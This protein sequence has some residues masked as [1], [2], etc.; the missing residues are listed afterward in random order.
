[1]A[2]NG[3]SLD[4]P[5]QARALGDAPAVIMGEGQLMSYRELDA[6]SNRLAH[7]LRA[8]GLVPGDHIAILME[9]NL[10][11]L[12]IAWAAQR[13]GLYYTAANS[14]L[15]R[16]EVQYILDD[17]GAKALVTSSATAAA[18]GALDLSR[19]QVRLCVGG[20]LENFASYES[21]TASQPS[22]PIRDECEGR[23][24][25]Y[26]SGT[27]GRP[28]GVQ[29]Q[30][31][32]TPLGDMSAAP[33]LIASRMA[34]SGA[35]PGAVYLSPA[36]LYH[37]APLVYS[38]SMIRLGA[39]VVV[40][41]H[42]D[43]VRCLELIAEHRVTHA[44]FVPTMFTAFSPCH[45]GAGPPR[46][47]EP[48]STWSMQRHLARWRRSAD[49][50]VVGADH[51]RVLRGNRGCRFDLDPAEEWI[52]HPGSVGK[53]VEPAHIVGPDG[54]ELPVG[55]EGV[56]YFEGGRT[57]EYHNNPDATASMTMTREGWRTLGDI[58]RLDAD[59][60]LYLTDRSRT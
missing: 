23:E 60:Y 3:I 48:Q 29:K 47:L 59:G 19:L 43:P 20:E 42:F 46:R 10:R 35:G 51:P 22:T 26:S 14:H 4:L 40:M 56:V 49:A 37:S 13:S 16:H 9:N 32:L 33:V 50:R 38:M 30:L 17:C 52:E 25:L 2:Q 6:A 12:E 31:P 44:Q 1:M 24:M 41:E 8:E 57:F 36:P 54:S 27:T 18:V 5:S 7:L 58:G 45:P 11:Y 21:S 53:P 55:E 28:K 15:R 34:L 39:V